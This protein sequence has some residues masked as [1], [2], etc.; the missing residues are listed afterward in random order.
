MFH[1]CM[2]LVTRRYHKFCFPISRSRVCFTADILVQNIFVRFVDREE[3][4]SLKSIAVLIPFVVIWLH[5]KGAGVTAYIENMTI[6]WCARI[7]ICIV[8]SGSM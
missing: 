7:M 4:V 3:N 5:R 2:S 6:T 8:A 1:I